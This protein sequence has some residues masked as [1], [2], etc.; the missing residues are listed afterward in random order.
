[1]TYS[2]N[3]EQIIEEFGILLREACISR[4]KVNSLDETAA[5]DELTLASSMLDV[6][7][8]KLQGMQALITYLGRK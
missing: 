6:P 3:L 2:Q 8:Q 4:G 1:V 7:E 5:L